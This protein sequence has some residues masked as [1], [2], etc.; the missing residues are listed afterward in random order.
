MIMC[1]KSWGLLDDTLLGAIEEDESTD[2]LMDKDK[3]GNHEELWKRCI[4]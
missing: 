2:I 1:L 3:A 4:I